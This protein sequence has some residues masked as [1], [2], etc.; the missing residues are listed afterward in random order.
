MEKKDER[1]EREDLC[2]HENELTAIISHF[3]PYSS[4]AIS[5]NM[6]PDISTAFSQWSFSLHLLPPPRFFHLSKNPLPL[7]SNV[8]SYKFI[9]RR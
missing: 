2:S 5:Y 4:L 1:R 7:P 6:G 3:L 9:S 8:G